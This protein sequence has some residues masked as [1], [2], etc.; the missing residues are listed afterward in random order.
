MVRRKTL[1]GEVWGSGISLESDASQ[2]HSKRR[3]MKGG[4]LDTDRHGGV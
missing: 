1:A 3:G 2:L 4:S